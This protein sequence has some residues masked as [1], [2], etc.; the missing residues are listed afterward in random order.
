MSSLTGDLRPGLGGSTDHS[1]VVSPTP[2]VVK[3]TTKI[4]EKKR[5]SE[6]VFRGWQVFAR[7]AEQMLGSYKLP[8]PAERLT[9]DSLRRWLPKLGLTE[10]QYENLVGMSIDDS[11]RFNRPWPLR[12]WLGFVAELKDAQP[13]PPTDAA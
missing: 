3:S 1:S 9:P 4:H 12:A 8:S 5:T 11:A 6:T 2:A 7:V 10:R 13:R